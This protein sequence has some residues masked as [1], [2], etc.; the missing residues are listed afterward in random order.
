M[1]IKDFV[2]NLLPLNFDLNL[3]RLRNIENVMK[4]FVV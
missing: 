4:E 3:S 2:K 1:K